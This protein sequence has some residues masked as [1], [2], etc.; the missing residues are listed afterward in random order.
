MRCF[1]EDGNADPMRSSIRLV[2]FE[3]ILARYGQIWAPV[4]ESYNRLN[5]E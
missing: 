2:Q 5:L 1:I 4:Q 3:L